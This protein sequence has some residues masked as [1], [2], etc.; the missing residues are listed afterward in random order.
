MELFDEAVA[1][2]AARYKAAELIDM[3]E[4]TLKR[5]RGANGTVAEDL[6]PD[7]ERAEQPYKLT[8]AEEVAVLRAYNVR[9]QK[10]APTVAP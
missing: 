1:G 8:Q 4:R 5:W 10:S 7:A 3:S 2:G 9:A 6:R